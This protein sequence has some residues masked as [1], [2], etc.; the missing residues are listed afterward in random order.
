MKIKFINGNKA[1]WNGLNCIT[2][3]AHK[4]DK[5]VLGCYVHRKKKGEKYYKIY[6]KTTRKKLESNT[7]YVV[8]QDNKKEQFK[9]LIHELCHWANSKVGNSKKMHRLIDKYIK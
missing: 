5:T 9:T 3:T 6:F 4:I 8:R 2:Y 1:A 7:V